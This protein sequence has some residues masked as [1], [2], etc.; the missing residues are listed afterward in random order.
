MMAV[1]TDNPT[2]Q[3]EGSNA[4]PLHMRVADGVC[5]QIAEG[6]VVPGEK[7][8]PEVE[9]ARAL[10][11]SRVTVSKAYSSLTSRGIISQHRGRGTFVSDDVCELLGIDKPHNIRRLTF[12]LGAPDIPSVPDHHRHIVMGLLDGIYSGLGNQGGNIVFC[13]EFSELNPANFSSDDAI[14]I[15]QTSLFSEGLAEEFL[16]RGVPVVQIWGSTALP[17]IPRI[18]YDRH[19]AAKRVCEHLVQCGYGSIGFIG[20]VPT[21]ERPVARKF[22]AYQHTLLDHGMDMQAAHVRGITR[23]PGEVFAAVRAMVKDGNL[24]DAVFIDTDL[25][26]MEG[27]R[28]FREYGIRVP[29]DIGVAGYDN[30]AE[31]ASFD[32][33][34]TTLSTPRSECGKGA[35]EMIMDWPKD[36]SVPESVLLAAELVPRNSTQKI[37]TKQ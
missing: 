7:L 18:S 17:S 24:P 34:L 25:H 21:D 31:S 30:I 10:G 27:V 11:V 3:Q 20:E 37:G 13:P 5:R 12:V 8:P 14:V 22:A 23:E 32:P 28:A 35:V 33:S 9:L 15:W 16:G 6:G 36:G 29:E 2:F 1:L 4:L 26:A 19:Q